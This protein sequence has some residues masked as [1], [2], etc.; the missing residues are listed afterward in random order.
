MK[1]LYVL[2]L[3]A[4][5]L[6]LLACD[7]NDESEMTGGNCNYI[8]YTGK[9]TITAIEDAPATENNCPNN[10]KKVSFEFVPD[11]ASSVNNYIF[12]NVIDSMQYLSINSGMNP[13]L[14]WLENN[15]VEVGQVFVSFREEIIEGTCTPVI[16]T[17]SEL[18]TMP[19]DGCN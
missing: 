2:C 4:V 13:S 1:N 3:I 16:Y 15:A 11:N 14:T 18:D 9:A 6:V 8:K 12:P 7:N 17:F 19:S 5:T 10:P